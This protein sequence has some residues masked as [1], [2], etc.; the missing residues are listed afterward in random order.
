[1]VVTVSSWPTSQRAWKQE[2]KRERPAYS[3]LTSY[4]PQY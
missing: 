1:M 2:K 4:Y 3:S